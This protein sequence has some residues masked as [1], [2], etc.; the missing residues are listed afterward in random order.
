MEGVRLKGGTKDKGENDLFQEVPSLT[1]TPVQ[2]HNHRDT[3]G[4]KKAQGTLFTALIRGLCAVWSGWVC[5]LITEIFTRGIT[6]AYGYHK[7]DEQQGNMF[8]VGKTTDSVMWSIYLKS[9]NFAT[10]T[11]T[12]FG[13]VEMSQKM[14]FH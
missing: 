9:Y 10:L 12:N 1:L 2:S 4:L 3:N 5:A 7:K 14:R 6:A 11:Q 8:T 13:R